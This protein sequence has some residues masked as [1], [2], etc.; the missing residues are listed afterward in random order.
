MSKELPLAPFERIAKN[1]GANRIASDAVEELRD[2]TE[3]KAEELAKDAVTFCKHAR[4]KTIKVDDIE[5]I[6]RTLEKER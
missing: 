5:M 6:K 2:M 1:A 4:R 3:E